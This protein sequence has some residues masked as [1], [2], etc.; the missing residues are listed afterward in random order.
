MNRLSFSLHNKVSDSAVINKDHFTKEWTNLS[1]SIEFGAF[2]EIYKK[3]VNDCERKYKHL[4]CTEINFDYSVQ[5]R[6]VD[7][8]D[9]YQ[10]DLCYNVIRL[11]YLLKF[12]MKYLELNRYSYLF[13]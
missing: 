12:I 3:L 7:E 8:L 10:L 2:E 4:D 9:E 5:I 6:N 11:V 13:S 1:I